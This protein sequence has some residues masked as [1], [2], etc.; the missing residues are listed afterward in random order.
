MA[1]I[2]SWQNLQT[3]LRRKNFLPES[4]PPAPGRRSPPVRGPRPPS[5]LGVSAGRG[6]GGLVAGCCCTCSA[7]DYSPISFGLSPEYRVP[8]T[9]LTP[10]PARSGGSRFL[11]LQPAPAPALHA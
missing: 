5:G 9:V 7:I 8:S 10:L 3:F 1:S 11:E 2:F 6:S 4:R